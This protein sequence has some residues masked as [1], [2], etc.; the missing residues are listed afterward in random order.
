MA[1]FHNP[2]YKTHARNLEGRYWKGFAERTRESLSVVDIEHC[3]AAD[4]SWNLDACSAVTAADRQKGFFKSMG[5]FTIDPTPIIPAPKSKSD[6]FDVASAEA[7]Q[8]L[9]RTFVQSDAVVMEAAFS[10]SNPGL[11]N[12][13]DGGSVNV[14]QARAFLWRTRHGCKNI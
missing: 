6:P 1:V 4:V 13:S 2:P 11:L 14:K 12:I 5:K 9:P 8:Q 3:G 7:T 10:L